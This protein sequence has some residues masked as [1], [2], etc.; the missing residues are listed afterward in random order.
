MQQQDLIHKDIEIS[1]KNG[2]DLG[3][4]AVNQETIAYFYL[5]NNNNYPVPFIF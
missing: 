5:K 1:I 4:C 3:F 2:L